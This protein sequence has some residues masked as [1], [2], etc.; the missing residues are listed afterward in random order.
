MISSIAAICILQK[1]QNSDFHGANKINS[2]DFTSR[3]TCSVQ[4]LKETCS[5]PKQ[6]VI[7]RTFNAFDVDYVICLTRETGFSILFY[8]VLLSLDIMK[9]PVP[10][11]K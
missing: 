7:H 3:P 8:F 11:V 6:N 9:C 2:C 10:R 1:Y 5:K 4:Y